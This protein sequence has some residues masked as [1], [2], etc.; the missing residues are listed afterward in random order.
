M[1]FKKILQ[2]IG[3]AVLAFALGTQV[4]SQPVVTTATIHAA[5]ITI[6]SAQLD[7]LNTT[8]QILVNAPG[9]NEVIVPVAIIA[10][11]KAGTD[12]YTYTGGNGALYLF[13]P[14]DFQNDGGYQIGAGILSSPGPATVPMILL[15]VQSGVPFALLPTQTNTPLVLATDGGSLSGGNGTLTVEIL[16]YTAT[17]PAS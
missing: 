13:W 3:V 11:Y 5:K 17:V 7:A 9:N 14:G 1:N 6:T 4:Y 10:T 8:P 16:Y 2:G 15:P 12:G